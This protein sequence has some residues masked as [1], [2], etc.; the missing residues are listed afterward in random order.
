VYGKGFMLRTEER[1]EEALAAFDHA[2]D[3]MQR[4]IERHKGKHHHGRGDGR[5]AA[6]VAEQIVDDETGELS[7][8]LARRKKFTLYPM[9]EDEAIV[10][11]RDLG[12]DNF[13][14]FSNAETGKINI[15]YRRRNGSY[16][17]IEPQIG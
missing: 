8:L 11:M 2:L 4:Q 14:V 5:S 3:N 9:S 7:P 13:F 10:Q 15:L 12:H 6:E 17:L 16:G 1:A